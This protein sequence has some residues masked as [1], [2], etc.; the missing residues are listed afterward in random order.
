M[1]FARAAAAVLALAWAVSSMSGCLGVDD[2]RASA[3]FEVQ[4]AIFQYQL[5]KHCSGTRSGLGACFLQLPDKADPTKELLAKFA[6]HVPPVKPVSAAKVSSRDAVRDPDTGKP[7][8]VLVIGWMQWRHEDVV[9]AT[10]TEY[11]SPSSG[12]IHTYTVE[13]HGDDWVVSKDERVGH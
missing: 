1:V 4:Q 7:G 6:K 11:T 5:A 3:D 8:K 9:T 10:G 12:S 13:R 2:S